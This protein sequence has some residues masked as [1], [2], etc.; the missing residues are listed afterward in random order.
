[1]DIKDIIINS[2]ERLQGHMQF[3]EYQNNLLNAIFYYYLSK[4]IEKENNKKLFKYDLNYEEAFYEENMEYYGNKIKNDSLNDYGYFIHPKNLY[5]NIIKEK[6]KIKELNNAFKQIQFMDEKPENLFTEIP[7]NYDSSTIDNYNSLLIDIN[8]LSLD[9]NDANILMKFFLNN[10]F[11]PCNISILLSKLVCYANETLKNVYDATCGSCS[12]LL[13]LNEEGD[14]ENFFGQEIKK[15]SCKLAKI[16]LMMHDIHPNNIN[17][18]NEDS[19]T[20][21]RKLPPIDAIVS[22]PPFLKKWESNKKLLNDKR[23]NTYKKLPP[24]SKASYAFLET[25]IYHLKDDGIMAVVMPQGVLFRSKAEK[26]IRKTFI[27]EKNYIDAVIGLPEKSFPKNVSACIL[28]LRKNRKKDEKIIIIDASKEYLKKNNLNILTNENIDKIVSTY[29]NRL[30][31]E[32]YSHNTTISEIKENDYNLNVK[33]YVDT[34]EEKDKINI[35]ETLN[36]IE[37]LEKEINILKK[38]EKELFHKLNL[39]L[40]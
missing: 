14:I 5:K 33:R 22:H 11:T 13:M 2:S 8:K 3:E 27:E 29:R 7:L 37:K 24:K 19:T 31:I 23:F 39:D 40:P 21:K 38:E 4:R 32:K 20:T 15:N 26:E 28:V 34:Y 18:Y 17:I 12:T 9:K 1:M 36:E 10:S 16:N 30:E 25:M 6:N 35:H